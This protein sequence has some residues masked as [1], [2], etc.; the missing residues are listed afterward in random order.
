[1]LAKRKLY[2][3]EMS[4]GRYGSKLHI[5]EKNFDNLRV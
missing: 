4:P 1:M 2:D 3:K 5:T